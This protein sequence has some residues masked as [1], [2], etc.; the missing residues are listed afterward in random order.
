MSDYILTKC[1]HPK[2]I[3]NPYLHEFMEVPCG[4]CKACLMRKANSS[5]LK[6]EL[7]RKASVYCLFVTL[8][9]SDK[10]LP[11]F[12]ILKD[13]VFLNTY[14]LI[15]DSGEV[16][17]N[18]Q[19]DDISL[20]R[21]LK[22]FNLNGLVPVV[23]SRD[24]QLYIK[25]LRKTID[26]KYHEKIRFYAV[27]EY[28]PVHYR[29][30]YHLLLF[31]NSKK[32]AEDI[33][34]IVSSCWK[35]GIVDSSFTRG[36]ASSYC[37]RYLNSNYT[38]PSIFKISSTKPFNRHS[39]RLGESFFV[40]SY[41][42]AYE[43]ITE[44]LVRKRVEIN[45]RYVDVSMWRNLTNRVFPRCKGFAEKTK[46]ELYYSYTSYERLCK[47]TKARTIKGMNRFILKSLISRNR[48]KEYSKEF[49]E[50]L[51]FFIS[52][53]SHIYLDIIIEKPSFQFKKDYVDPIFQAWSKI[54]SISRHFLRDICCSTDYRVVD[55]KLTRLIDF[56]KEYE[57]LQLRDS[58]QK[59]EDSKDESVLNYY[60]INSEHPRE[61]LKQENFYLVFS[62][63][64]DEKFNKSIKHKKLNDL[65]N[66]FN[67]K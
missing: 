47:F 8:T 27:S 31:F 7:E 42:E 41:E 3:F 34:Q 48:G 22:K 25:R 5:T 11:V 40:Q 61:N 16:V 43:A 6:L 28:G 53:Y 10:N 36:K 62:S 65:N 26:K 50:L 39:V 30:H 21:L 15:D 59:L 32:L 51:D 1:L 58:L 17:G 18:V 54:L 63:Q 56:Y 24:L 55:S 52:E 57:Y 33:R 4:K 23:S 38:L 14:N 29:P 60:Y 37:A 2:K 45:G 49:N 19:I 9:Y 20:S 44:S 66:I 12:S 67:N 13:D 64:I 46:C 35:L